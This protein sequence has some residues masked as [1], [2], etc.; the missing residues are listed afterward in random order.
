MQDKELVESDLKK[1]S[2]LSK[3]MDTYFEI[4]GLNIKI[5]LDP[6][7]GLIPGI[8]DLIS[9]IIGA[10]PISVAMKHNLNR[11]IILQMMINLGIDYVIGHIPV[12]GDIF[13]VFYRANTKN[14]ELIKKG[15]QDPNKQTRHSIFFV[16][17]IFLFLTVI[18]VSPIVLIVM[19]LMAAFG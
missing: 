9:N 2:A 4:P 3:L 6:I 13:D 19:L 17:T 12:L 10:Y 11:S 8:G 5:G 15:L 1:V 14:L 16:T 18:L 7:I